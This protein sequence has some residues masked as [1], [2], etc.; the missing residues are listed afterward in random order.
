MP[1]SH[2]THNQLTFLSIHCPPQMGQ[3]IRPRVWQRPRRRDRKAKKQSL[4]MLFIHNTPGSGYDIHNDLLSVTHMKVLARSSSPEP[5]LDR[6]TNS[7]H[8]ASLLYTCIL[9]IAPSGRRW[10]HEILL[11]QRAFLYV[12]NSCISCLGG[13]TASLLIAFVYQGSLLFFPLS[14]LSSSLW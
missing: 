1:S 13:V 2:I 8:L 6:E 3:G 9:A 10:K 11:A 5:A 12:Y 14:L 4:R 7:F